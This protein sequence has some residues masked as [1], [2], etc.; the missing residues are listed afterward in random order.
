MLYLG[1]FKSEY[2]LTVILINGIIW[3]IVLQLIPRTF[4]HL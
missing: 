3:E 2:L 1:E 4:T